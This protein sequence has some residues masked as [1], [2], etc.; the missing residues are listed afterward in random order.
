MGFKCTACGTVY[1]IQHPHCGRCGSPYL[2]YTSDEE[3]SFFGEKSKTPPSSG[4]FNTKTTEKKGSN[5]NLILIVAA[6]V[7]GYFAYQNWDSLSDK[8]TGKSSETKPVASEE[9][10]IDNTDAV[11]VEDVVLKEGFYEP[12]ESGGEIVIRPGNKMFCGDTEG[13]YHIKG[14]KLLYTAKK[15][16]GGIPIHDMEVSEFIVNGDILT[17]TFS[18]GEK[19]NYKWVGEVTP[20]SSGIIASS[21]LS[22]RLLTESD[23]YGKT[24]QQ[25]RIMRNEI[26]A[27]HG[28]KFKSQD[29]Q[30][31]FS[32]QDWYTPLYDEVKLNEVEKKNVA[33]IQRH[34]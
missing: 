1:T 10:T 26:Y 20:L 29:L 17:A 14:N 16:S 23:L 4:N 22:T 2:A 31:Y 13:T 33:F 8:S 18:N 28:R 19:L 21:A 25:L 30:D 5:K 27:R 9:I 15:T 7:V 34:E 6:L 12:E 3:G 24:K 32:A 11:M